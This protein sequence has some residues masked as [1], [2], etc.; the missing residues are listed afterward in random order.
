[1]Y[2]YALFCRSEIKRE[3]SGRGNWGSPTDEI[4]VYVMHFSVTLSVLIGL[5][6]LFNE[7]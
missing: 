5:L 7:H 1:M 2:Y 4:V 3:G 6:D